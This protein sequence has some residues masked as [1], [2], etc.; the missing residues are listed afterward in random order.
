M[1]AFMAGEG[2]ETDAKE[3]LTAAT[4]FKAS[5]SFLKVLPCTTPDHWEMLRVGACHR[6]QCKPCHALTLLLTCC[7]FD[8]PGI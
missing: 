2:A 1:R 4:L 5:A 8:L 6:H 3:L 7:S